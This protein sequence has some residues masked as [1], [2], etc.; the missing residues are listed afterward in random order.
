MYNPA[1]RL[2]G[3]ARD[4]RLGA[5]R[6]LSIS[7][8]ETLLLTSTTTMASSLAAK[9]ALRTASKTKIATQASRLRPTRTWS[10]S[11][12]S[13]VHRAAALVHGTT[14]VTSSA[15]RGPSLQSSRHS[16]PLSE[17]LTC[18]SLVDFTKCAVSTFDVHPDRVHAQRR[19]FEIHTWRACHGG[20]HRRVP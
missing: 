5:G 12:T 8:S 20:R 9:S 2:G 1:S 13:S 17:E 10:Q 7:H 19:L 3:E 4:F 18:I 11:F 15:T 16:P 14:L 6:L